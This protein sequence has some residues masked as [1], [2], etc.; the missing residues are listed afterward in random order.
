MINGEKFS[1]LHLTP[2]ADFDLRM[3]KLCRLIARQNF[4]SLSAEQVRSLILDQD[5]SLKDWSAFQESWSRLPLDE[6][7]ADGGRYRRRR[8]ATF[9]AGASSLTFRLEPHQPHYQSRNNNFL[10][11]GV[12]RHFEAIDDATLASNTMKSLLT[13]CCIL[14]GRLSPY[15]DWH[16]ELHQF[17][18]ETDGTR[19]G[20]PTPEGPHRDG[21]SFVMMLMVHRLNVA[22]GETIIYDLEDRRVDEFTLTNPLE[23]VLVN[24]ERVRHGVSPITSFNPDKPGYRDVFVATF[25]HKSDLAE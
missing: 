24:D 3:H 2:S 18:I 16:I 21:V 8:Y 20:Q 25:R 5:L 7:M 11:G 12:S 6:Y 15:S 23:M 22:G 10:N 14:F 13:F 4:C 19:I 17:R 1:S 9:T